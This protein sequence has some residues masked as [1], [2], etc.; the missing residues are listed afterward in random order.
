MKRPSD[1]FDRVQVYFRQQGELYGSELYLD[2]D[3]GLKADSIQPESL[4]H[5]FEEIKNCQKCGLSASR[6]KFVFGVGNQHAKIMCIGEAPGFDEDR[7]GEPFVGAAGQLLNKIL[8]AIGFKR[9]EVY[10]ANIIKCRPPQNRDPEPEEIAECA[11]H[12]MKQIELIR[13]KLI[14]VLGRIAAQALLGVQDSISNLRT[15]SH[16]Y[17]DIPVVVTYHPAALLRSEQWKR[18]TWEDLKRLRQM[19]D[20]LVGDKPPLATTNK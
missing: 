14:L 5:Y 12:L 16:S 6:T 11:P 7:Q 20:E 2:A 19:Y 9:E 8:A 10:I 1:I 13:P 15:R 3:V 17:L 18:P 4:A